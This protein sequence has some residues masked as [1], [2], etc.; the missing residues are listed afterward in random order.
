MAWGDVD[1]DRLMAVG[2]PF[3]GPIGSFVPCNYALM[4][5]VATTRNEKKIL[6]VNSAELRPSIQIFTSSGEELSKFVVCTASYSQILTN[7]SGTKGGL[8]VWDGQTLRN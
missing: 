2:A 7:A 4:S 3:G 1:L 6:S 5:F 8:S